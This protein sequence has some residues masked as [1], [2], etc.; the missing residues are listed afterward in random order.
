MFGHV[1]DDLSPAEVEAAAK[2]YGPLADRVRE[3]VAAT[4]LTE[5]D[6]PDV[7]K[8][9]E[10]IREATALLGSAAI[11]GSFGVRWTID[12][13][14]RTWGNA[15]V[16]L[17][18]PV[19]PPLDIRHDEEQ[20]YADVVL[21]PQYEGPP[22]LVHGGIIAAMLDQVLGDAAVNAGA[23]GMTGTLNIRYRKGTP[24]GPVRIQAAVDRVEGVK[25]YV[26]GQVVVD[27]VVR[28]EAEGI[29]ILPKEVRNL[30]DNPPPGLLAPGD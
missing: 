19:A 16:G 7:A 11:E 21:G 15:V 17:R 30:G 10:L 8:A 2:L 6:G 28:A 12:G 29:F 27:D 22:T 5:V 24:L 13:K 18:N 20:T 26:T 23:P 9:I 25:T 14:R 4:V 3:L 1:M